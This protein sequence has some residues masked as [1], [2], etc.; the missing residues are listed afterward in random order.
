MKRMGIVRALL[1]NIDVHSWMCFIFCD[2]THF[3]TPF[4]Q[5]FNAFDV[6]DVPRHRRVE[7]EELLVGL[8]GA[9]QV[10]ELLPTRSEQD[11]RGRR[12]RPECHGELAVRRHAM[13]G[14]DI[15]LRFSA[16]QLS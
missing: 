15:A 5:R 16:L 12:A 13:Q 3:W 14:R 11:E 1:N 10:S 2:H 4:S 8:D 9:L 7:E 6:L